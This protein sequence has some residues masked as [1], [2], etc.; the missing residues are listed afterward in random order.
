MLIRTFYMLFEFVRTWKCDVFFIRKFGSSDKE[1]KEIYKQVLNYEQDT[2]SNFFFPVDFWL[3][4]L[5]WCKHFK[6]IDLGTSSSFFQKKINFFIKN[7]LIFKPFL[8]SNNFLCICK[9]TLNLY[10]CALHT[11]TFSYTFLELV[12]K[13]SRGAGKKSNWSGCNQ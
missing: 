2:V 6:F 5:L 12:T 11:Y 8:R 3:Q 7:F 4:V 10:T 13:H 1:N 9:W